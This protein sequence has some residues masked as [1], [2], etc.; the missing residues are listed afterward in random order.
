MLRNL[1]VE[2][3]GLVGT[4]AWQVFIVMNDLKFSAACCNDKRSFRINNLVPLLQY[5]VA[6]VSSHSIRS[7]LFVHSQE[8]KFHVLPRTVSFLTFVG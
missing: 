7:V 4:H 6:Q 3:G 5:S 2:N 1:L 8:L